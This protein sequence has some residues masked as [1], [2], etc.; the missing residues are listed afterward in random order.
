MV[1]APRWRVTRAIVEPWIVPLVCA[2]AHATVD[3]VGFASPGALEEAAKFGARLRSDH[4]SGSVVERDD[5]TVR[6][7]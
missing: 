4:R 3:G 6:G 5:G 7:L 2:M 1:I